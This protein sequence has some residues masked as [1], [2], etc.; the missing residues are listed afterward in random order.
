MGKVKIF[1]GELIVEESDNDIAILRLYGSVDYSDV[2]ITD[3]GLHHRI[4]LHTPIERGFRVLDK[5]TIEV[6]AIAM[7]IFGRGWEPRLDG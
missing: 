7:I 6:Q 3:A 2:S 5:V 4:A 1:D